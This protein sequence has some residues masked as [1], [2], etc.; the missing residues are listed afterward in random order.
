[1]YVAVNVGMA[2]DKF[3]ALGIGH[4]GKIKLAL[5]LAELRVEDNVQ[6]QVAQ[7]LLNALHIAI[8]NGVGQFVCLLYGVISE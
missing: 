1:M 5:L 6:E 8:G 7:L 4:V 2:V 3:V